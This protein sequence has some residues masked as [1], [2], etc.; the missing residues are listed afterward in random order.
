MIRPTPLTAEARLL[1]DEIETRRKAKAR[2]AS[3]SCW[4]SNVAILSE[5]RFPAVLLLQQSESGSGEPGV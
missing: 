1:A 5:C 3:P 2:L 4:L